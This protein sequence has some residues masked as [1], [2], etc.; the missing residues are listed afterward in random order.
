[1]VQFNFRKNMFPRLTPILFILWIVQNHKS[2]LYG[3]IA[4]LNWWITFFI[5]ISITWDV[6]LIFFHIYSI[7]NSICQIRAI[8]VVMPRKAFINFDHVVSEDFFD[9]DRINH[10]LLSLRPEFWCWVSSNKPFL[11]DWCDDF[12][13]PSGYDEFIILSARSRSCFE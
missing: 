5:R 2:S 10:F 6:Y 11:K 12:Q 8:P 4:S 1:M 7:Q 13:F 9:K 3:R